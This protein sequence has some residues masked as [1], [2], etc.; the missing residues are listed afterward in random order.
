MHIEI[1]IPG[2]SWELNRGDSLE[3]EKGNFL[4]DPALLR[5]GKGASGGAFG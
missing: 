2:E 3:Q 5:V 1:K 4:P